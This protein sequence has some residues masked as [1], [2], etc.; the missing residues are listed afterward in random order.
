M[1]R[2]GLIKNTRTGHGP[3]GGFEELPV[4]GKEALLPLVYMWSAFL[5]EELPTMATEKRRGT[6]V[7]IY[8]L[9]S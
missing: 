3:T 9:T 4:M 5:L 2:D 8:K 6:P 7:T 1:G